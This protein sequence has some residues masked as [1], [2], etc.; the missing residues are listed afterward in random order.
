MVF[1]SK[2]TRELKR[3]FKVADIAIPGTRAQCVAVAQRVWEDL[4]DFEGRKGK[5]LSEAPSLI[6]TECNTRA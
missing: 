5:T 1:Y 2:L 4:Y 3:Q 6:T